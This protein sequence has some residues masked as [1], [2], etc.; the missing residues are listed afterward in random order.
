MY[1]KEL[2]YYFSTPIAYIVIGLYLLALGLFLW[3]IPGEYNIPDSGYSQVDGLFRLTPWLFML[4]CP[5]LTM[6][7]FA[8]EKATG[9]W[10]ILRAQPIP[11]WKIVLGKWLAALSVLLLALLPA[12]LHYFLVRSIAEPV[13]N[14]DSGAFFGSFIGLFFLAATFT[15][16]GTFSST[17][18]RSQIVA[19]L[20]GATLCFFCYYGFALLASLFSG[21]IVVN[22][23]EWLGM[24]THYDSLA[25]GVIDLRDVVYF[26]S[27]SALFILSSLIIL[28][29]QRI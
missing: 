12:L 24:N 13:G 10:H 11:L 15:A 18:T 8:E 14:I 9:T 7:L 27:V 4:V 26:L 20:V 17:F 5:A 3:V 21:G 28:R 25:R 2:R 22:T 6:R 1:I 29:H 16:I 23:I 19:F